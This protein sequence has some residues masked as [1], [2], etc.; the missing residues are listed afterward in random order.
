MALEVADALQAAGLAPFYYRSQLSVGEDIGKQI[1]EALSESRA[2][3]AIVSPEAS[4]SSMGML[5]IGAASAWNKPVFL[6]VNGPSSTRLP[7]VLH[8]YPAYP[9]NRLDD[10]VQAIQKGFEPLTDNEHT[11]LAHAYEEL[12]V[13]VDQ[14]S[15]S[16]GALRDL[17][18]DFNRRTHRQLSG[19]R[20]LSELLRLRKRGRLPRI[21]LR[22]S[23]PG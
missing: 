20:I 17:T 8:S 11:E 21:K 10:V 5:E 6:L 2:L 14:L 15:Q 19:E 13:S 23:A 9:L 7:N 22:G 3:I 16:P 4:S 18:L 1:W 12:N